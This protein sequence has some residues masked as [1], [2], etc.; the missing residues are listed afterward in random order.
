MR[1][2]IVS[3]YDLQG[4]AAI[5]ATRLMHALQRSGCDASMVVRTRLGSDPQ[6]VQAGSNTGNRLRF[7]GERGTLF[8]QNRFSRK[9]LFDVS[10]ANTGVCITRLP[11]FKAADVIHLHWINQG[12]LSLGEIERILASGKKVVWTLHDM[13]SFTGI[14]HHAAGCPHYEE[15]CGNCPYLAAPSPGDLSHRVF[16]KKQAIYRKG[17]ITFVAC[18]QWLKEL[19]DKSPLTRGHRVV[20][21]PNPIDTGTYTPEEKATA[22]EELH[23]PRDKKIVLFAAAKASDPRKGMEYLFRAGEI[24]VRER[25]D[26]LFLIAGRQGEEIA[27][28]LPLPSKNLGY[29]APARMAALYRAADLYITPSL[30][31]NLPNTIMEAMACGT[32]CVGFNTGGIPEMIDHGVN[33]YVAEYKNAEDFAKG[34]AR[35]LYEEDGERLSTRAREKVLNEYSEAIIANRYINEYERE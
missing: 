29:V 13:W 10:I 34:I 31:E 8:L 19:A 24:M 2:L 18:S 30:L 23:L 12:M 11:Q 1:V 4:G 15:G 3:T 21:I 26:L 16:Q 32:P 14:C 5:A 25:S 22:R 7:Y 33:G 6:V 27:E 28:R 20:A 35:I 9:H 17:N